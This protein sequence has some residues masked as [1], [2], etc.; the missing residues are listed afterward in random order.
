LV[1]KTKFKGK[2]AALHGDISQKDRE[3]IIK[4]LHS[5]QIKHLIATNIAARGL[6]LPNIDLIV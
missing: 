1:R 5:G 6:D 3:Y 2:S 4:A